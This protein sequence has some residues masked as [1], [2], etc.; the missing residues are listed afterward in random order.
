M[1]PKEID[2]VDNNLVDE[3]VDNNNNSVIDTDSES[4]YDTDSFTDDDSNDDTDDFEK[5][6]L[7]RL[8]N[9]KKDIE[10]FKNWFKDKTDDSNVY[11]VFEST[12][13]PE[14]RSQLYEYI[15]EFF[16]NNDIVT[17]QLLAYWKILI[18]NI[19]RLNRKYQV[20]ASKINVDE[21]THDSNLKLFKEKSMFRCF[22]DEEPICY[23]KE[24]GNNYYVS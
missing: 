17:D 6:Q 11:N 5:Q 10:T 23:F 2:S 1:E 12:F 18:R 22:M 14:F 16:N 3:Q 24:N 7:E 4:D 20:I 19:M 13:G 15:N 9:A 8:E 21:N